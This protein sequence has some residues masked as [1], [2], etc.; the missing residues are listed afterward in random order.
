[1]H[2]TDVVIIG[3]GIAGLTL[4]AILGRAG[5][6]V[7]LQATEFQDKLTVFETLRMFRAF[8]AEPLRVHAAGAAAAHDG[9]HGEA[10]WPM[11]LA[12]T[13]TAAL[14]SRVAVGLR[15]AVEAGVTDGWWKYGCAAV[16][17]I[18]RYGESAPAGVLFKHF[19][20]TADNVAA[21]V[22]EVVAG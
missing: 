2:K 22:R 13:L 15:I 21:V 1:M 7:Q 3:G 12:L 10:P 9:D 20:F 4:A 5:I 8:F 14:K 19:H 17:G 18:D 11:V 6:G 16:V